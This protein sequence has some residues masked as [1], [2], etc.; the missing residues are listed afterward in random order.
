MNIMIY[1]DLR[2]Q[3]MKTY[4][5]RFL[6]RMFGKSVVHFGVNKD[7]D[8]IIYLDIM[9]KKFYVILKHFDFKLYLL[10]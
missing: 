1:I 9:K 7:F 4:T 8:K 2:V 10:Y 5:S 3:S 6:K